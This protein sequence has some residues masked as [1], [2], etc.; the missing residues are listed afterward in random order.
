MS[1]RLS[2]QPRA[3]TD[4]RPSSIVFLGHAHRLRRR[5]A[6]ALLSSLTACDYDT[7]IDNAT[8]ELNVGDKLAAQGA[9][10]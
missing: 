8:V 10:P 5:T 6:L 2:S 3:T 4:R 1:E 9:I 7:D